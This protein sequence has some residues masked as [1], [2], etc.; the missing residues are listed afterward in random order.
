M[1]K[2]VLSGAHPKLPNDSSKI[3]WKAGCVTGPVR[4][5]GRGK[6]TIDS[7]L[8]A[9]PLFASLQPGVDLYP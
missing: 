2:N 1:L 7:P 3:T 5:G 9:Y 4:W 6:V 8:T